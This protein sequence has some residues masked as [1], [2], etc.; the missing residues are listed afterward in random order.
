[1]LE[2]KPRDAGWEA[3]MLPLCYAATQPLKFIFLQPPYYRFELEGVDQVTDPPTLEPIVRCVHCPSVNQYHSVIHCPWHFSNS[4]FPSY[5]PPHPLLAIVC[6][7]ILV[8]YPVI[9]LAVDQAYFY[10]CYEKWQLTRAVASH[11]WWLC[12]QFPCSFCLGGLPDQWC[13]Y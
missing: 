13:E 12:K 3:R 4:S 1:M 2:I 8:T 6:Y 11:Q 9:W 7:N 5:I 10:L